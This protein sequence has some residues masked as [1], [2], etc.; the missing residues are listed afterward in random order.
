MTNRRP[1]GVPSGQWGIPDRNA[2][3]EPIC[4]WCRGAIRPP[5]RTFCSASCVHEWRVR[6]DV[7]YVREQVLARDRGECQL[8]GLNLRS[9]ERRWRLA[10]PA[11]HD[12]TARR[13]WR[14]ARP[15]WEADHVVPV[16]DGGGGCGLENY[17]LLCRDCHVSVTSAWRRQRV[18]ITNRTR[19]DHPTPHCARDAGVPA[20]GD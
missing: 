14:Q 3:G 17:R 19:M 16:A 20:S 11:P 4:R 1:R 13:R 7:S 12:R 5:R 8:C 9:A 10:R 18:P 2:D 15:R 6:S